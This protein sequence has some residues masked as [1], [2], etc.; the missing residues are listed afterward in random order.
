MYLALPSRENLTRHNVT[1]GTKAHS[2][3]YDHPIKI[4][5]STDGGRFDY[6][7]TNRLAVSFAICK[8]ESSIY[9]VY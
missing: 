7:F 8:C 5:N 1:K 6:T 4:E 3:L 9:R 2:I